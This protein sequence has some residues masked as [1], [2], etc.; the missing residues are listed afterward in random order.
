MT[1]VVSVG[2]S[3]GLFLASSLGFAM[4]LSLT[5][6]PGTLDN[7]G[8]FPPPVS[9][10]AGV[11]GGSGTNGGAGSGGAG[12][13]STAGCD[14]KPLFIGTTSKYQC[15]L[16]GAC[17]DANGSAGNFSMTAADWDQ[18]LVGVMPKGGG[19]TPSMCQASTKPYL[20]AKSSPAAG[21]LI[22]KLTNPTCGMMMPELTGPI[23]AADMT[24]I[25]AWAQALVNQ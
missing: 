25:K 3:K 20:I 13:G 8:A 22:D 5:G 16:D 18:H 7:P 19:A 15:T 24:C 23:S 21:L 2:R 1:R 14:V 17:H 4:L 12:T 11:S 10:S 9:G 6:C